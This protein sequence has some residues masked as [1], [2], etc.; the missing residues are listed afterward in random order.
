[1][2]KGSVNQ[3][4]LCQ[5]YLEVLVIQESQEGRGD[6]HSHISPMEGVPKV[7]GVGVVVG[8]IGVDCMEGV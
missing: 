6:H 7:A 3:L 8:S 5:E 2:A 4:Q 1:M